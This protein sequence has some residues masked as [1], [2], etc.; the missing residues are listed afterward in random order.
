MNYLTKAMVILVNKS[1]VALHGRNFV[2]PDNNLNEENLNYLL[3][4]VS[5]E[6]FGVLLYPNLADKAGVC[7]YKYYCQ[8]HIPGRK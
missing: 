4:I 1:T 7:M 5:A 8:P 3:Y 6:M 2:E